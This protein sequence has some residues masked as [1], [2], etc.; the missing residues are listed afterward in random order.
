MRADFFEYVPQFKLMI[1]GNHKPGQRSV[2]EAMRRRLHLIPFTV[3]IPKEERDP[4]LAEKLHEE[5]PG[6][7][8]W[9]IDGCLAWQ[10]KRLNPP[11]VVRDATSEY[12]EAEDAVGRWIEEACKAGPGLSA[13]AA[14]LFA[15]WKI[16]CDVAGEYAGSQ[17]RFS[18]ML[19]ARGYT[20]E[21]EGG[22]GR[23]VFRGLELKSE[24]M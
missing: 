8:Q 1:A 16:W 23:R 15:N 3:T 21:R 12:M 2:D 13:K 22:T 10:Q 5:W 17:K 4:Y 6:I 18:Q 7:L 19:E 14:D 24:G 20:K 9:A 11:G